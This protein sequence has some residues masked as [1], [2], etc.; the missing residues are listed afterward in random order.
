MEG[1]KKA[2]EG[3]RIR[4]AVKA[5]EKLPPPPVV[6]AKKA[7][8]AEAKP[9][10]AAVSEAR[11]LPGRFDRAAKIPFDYSASKT[12]LENYLKTF[13]SF[14]RKAKDLP[15]ISRESEGNLRTYCREAIE[16]IGRESRTV[17]FERYYAELRKLLAVSGVNLEEYERKVTKDSSPA[18]LSKAA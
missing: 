5:E 17:A 12:Q 6:V 15:G 18:K 13:V 7:P 10:L 8:L 14:A 4:K 9:R 16:S 2:G 11:V 3:V 1:T